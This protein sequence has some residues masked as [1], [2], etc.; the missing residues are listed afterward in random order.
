M[1]TL[2]NDLRYAVRTFLK[3]PGFAAVT[4]ATLALGIGATTAVF[5][6]VNGVLLRPL[7]FPDSDRIVRIW[8]ANPERGIAFFSVS[9]ADY[10]E[11]KAQSRSFKAMAAY[12]REHAAALTGKGDPR[13]VLVS[14]A[15]PDLFALLGVR[16]VSGP[17]FAV[18]TASAL[19]R[20]EGIAVVTDG[21]RRREYGEDV[22]VVGRSLTLDGELYRV[23]GVMPPGFAVPNSDAEVWTPSEDSAETDHGKRYLRVLG[24]LAD[25]ASLERARTELSVIAGRLAVSHPETNE[26]WTVALRT[27]AESV[28]GNSFRSSVTVLFGVVAIVLLIACANVANLWIVRATGR[29]SEIG[30]RMAL[31]ASRGRLVRQLLT[32]SVTLGLLAGTLGMMIALGGLDV[33]RSMAPAEIPRLE[34]VRIDGRVLGFSVMVSVLTGLGFGLLPA[35]RLSKT[36]WNA[37]LKQASSHAGGGGARPRLRGALITGQIGLALI[38]LAGAG[39]LIQSLFRL[40]R[41]PLGFSSSGIVTARIALPEARYPDLPRVAAFYRLLLERV[42]AIPGVESA[43]AVSLAPLRDP[44]TAN[45]FAP[46]TGTLPQR[47]EAPDA[48]FRVVTDRYFETMGIRRLSGQNFSREPEAGPPS[49]VI[50]H[51]MARRFWPNSDP[52]GKRIRIGDLANGPWITVVGVVDDAT[53]GNLEAASPRPM[54]YLPHPQEDSRAMTLVVRAPGGAGG[55]IDEIRREVLSL[56][57]DQPLSDIR[58]MEDV[59]SGALAQRRF[60]MSLFGVFAA[61][62]LGLASLGIFGLV[63]FLVAQRTREMGLRMAL[64]ARPAD[65]VRLVIG[66]G[67]RLALAGIGVGLAAGLA[68]TRVLASQLYDTNP[69]NAAVFGTAAAVLLLAALLASWLPARRAGRIDPMAALRSE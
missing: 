9:P 14:R 27:L 10:R 40:Q 34:S 64:G 37:W 24:R 28:V 13:E 60:T 32:E 68:L 55:V 5:S 20:D 21:F 43:A 22:E 67:F 26:H 18:P 8:S 62:A 51:T 44:N 45:V 52:I 29:Q 25:S 3:K 38:L 61:M 58:T 56:D 31:G 50:N 49:A 39:L 7:P 63:S 16:P 23:V 57:R 47:S 65:L 59:I 36:N 17:G 15:S 33:I 1:S 6:V 42:R 54:I 48:D 69:T 41:V 2:W 11:W 53:Y 30:V 46:E 35:L 4:I 19:A 12:E 66:Q